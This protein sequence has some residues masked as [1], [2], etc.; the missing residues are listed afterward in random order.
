[1]AV[2]VEPLQHLHTQATY[3]K[4]EI[5]KTTMTSTVS[6][7]K[8]DPPQQMHPSKTH[9]CPSL[10]MAP[11]CSKTLISIFAAALRKRESRDNL[12]K[13]ENPHY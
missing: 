12:D 4:R 8:R 2:V 3:R 6:E 9:F 11:I 7:N 1:M 13:G 10:E 5:G